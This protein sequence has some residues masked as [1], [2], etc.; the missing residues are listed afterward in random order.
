MEK[1]NDCCLVMLLIQSR[2][3][4]LISVIPEI[5]WHKLHK[6]PYINKRILC[7]ERSIAI[8]LCSASD[9]LCS[10][11]SFFLFVL[12]QPMFDASVCIVTTC[13]LFLQSYICPF[14][15][16]SSTFFCHNSSLTAL[17]GC[18]LIV[19]QWMRNHLNDP[20]WSIIKS[21]TKRL[22]SYTFALYFCLFLFEENSAT[23]IKCNISRQV[24]KKNIYLHLLLFILD[25]VCRMLMWLSVIYN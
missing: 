5:Y 3:H 22:Q 17:C 7:T 16:T 20:Q 25:K 19:T 8:L 6:Y 9:K 2:F 23:R 18:L 1:Y 13:Q 24:F 21:L 4:L 11:F 15:S 14:T 10:A 12:H